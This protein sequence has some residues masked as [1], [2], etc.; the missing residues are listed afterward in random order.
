MFSVCRA[1]CKSCQDSYN[2]DVCEDDFFLYKGVF[3]KCLQRCPAGYLADN[4]Q[5][6]G[7]VCKIG[8]FNSSDSYSLTC[9]R[10]ED[11]R[12]KPSCKK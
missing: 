10:V 6:S 4:S 11:L 1:N 8:K 2:C 3:S 5:F 9:Q 12:S 7:K